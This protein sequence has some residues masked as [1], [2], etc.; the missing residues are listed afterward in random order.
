CRIAL[1]IQV[2]IETSVPICGE[3]PLRGPMMFNLS[4]ASPTTARAIEGDDKPAAPNPQPRT[5]DA[6]KKLRR[7]LGFIDWLNASLLSLLMDREHNVISGQIAVR[8]RGNEGGWKRPK[9]S[10]TNGLQSHFHQCCIT[11]VRGETQ[12]GNS[13]VRQNMKGHLSCARNQI[14]NMG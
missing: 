4:S 5:A 11:S 9:A 7:L 8:K 12:I 3:K 13:A 1:R 6:F 2:N 14:V 10:L